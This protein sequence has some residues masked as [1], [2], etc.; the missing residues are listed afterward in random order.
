[1]TSGGIVN[2]TDRWT[3]LIA[4]HDCPRGHVAI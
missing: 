2:L 4:R 3:R 1:M